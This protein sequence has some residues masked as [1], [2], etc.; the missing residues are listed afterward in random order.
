MTLT[1]EHGLRKPNPG[2]G[3]G[4]G[5]LGQ[6]PLQLQAGDHGPNWPGLWWNCLAGPWLCAMLV[7]YVRALAADGLASGQ[8]L[9]WWGSAGATA[10]AFWCAYRLCKPTLPGFVVFLVA[11]DFFPT[12]PWRTGNPD[13]LTHVLSAAA[14]AAAALWRREQAGVGVRLWLRGTTSGEPNGSFPRL[15]A[16]RVSA[17]WLDLRPEWRAG[18]VLFLATRPC[19]TLLGVLSRAVLSRIHSPGAVPLYSPYASLSM[20]AVWDSDWY[21]RIALHGYNGIPRTNP[22]QV[23]MSDVVFFP[24][25]PVLSRWL[26]W[27]I[28]SDYV[29]GLLISNACL[30]GAS[31]LLY[32]L[33]R[34][35][36]GEPAALRAMEYLY[37][38]PM[39]FVFSAF[40]T[41][42]LFLFLV[43]ASLYCARRERWLL[44]GACGL[45]AALTRSS[46]VLL[47]LPALLEYLSARDFE[48]RRIRPNVLCLL[49][50][51]LG[52]C[53]F[54]AFCYR[55]TGDFLAFSHV[56]AAWGRHWGNPG[57]VVWSSLTTSDL[58]G[59]FWGWF[60][61]IF[62]LVVVCGVRRVR[63]SY[64]LWA[65][66]MIV[67]P[68]ATGTVM[69]MPRYV[70][71]VFPFY[72]ICA[73]M[74]GNARFHR[75]T[76]MA[77]AL[78][79]G[80]LMVFWTKGFYITV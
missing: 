58:N 77:L 20:W 44:C 4:N 12:G 11:L 72:L 23:G 32:R 67:A 1:S 74:S 29:A 59:H 2:R 38:F 52:T 65:L 7:Q 39:A 78:F 35:D 13:T 54:G 14:W 79:Q 21:M 80:C 42:S 75:A 6:P 73:G 33:A 37:L 26:G 48:W 36:Y 31:V 18:L 19:L 43:L 71:P 56:E 69:S 57:T 50:I 49:L 15:W 66:A 61:L 47:V 68:L 3:A 34:V 40:Y 9:R 51:P 63:M 16:S 45:L 70:V 17:A 5:E 55:L 8:A 62:L 53:L 10:A 30:V 27:G 46:G 76:M 41:E 28:G 22:G 25:Y 24:L 64:W 60:T